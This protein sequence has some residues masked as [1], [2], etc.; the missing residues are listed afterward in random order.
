MTETVNLQFSELLSDLQ[1]QQ[2][3]TAPNASSIEKIFPSTES[4]DLCL[5]EC[6]PASLC[7]FIRT[8]L[9]WTSAHSKDRLSK[10]SMLP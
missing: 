8:L 4:F 6:I 1:Q 9:E 10:T 3:T 5:Y 2:Q 7:L